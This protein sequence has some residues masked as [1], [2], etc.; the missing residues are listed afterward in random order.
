[1]K[2]SNTPS[3][4]LIDVQ[5]CQNRPHLEP[6]HRQ[7]NQNHH[8]T[9]LGLESAHFKLGL[10]DV[11]CQQPPYSEK[12]QRRAAEAQG[13]LVMMSGGPNKLCAGISQLSCPAIA[14]G[15]C[16]AGVLRGAGLFLPCSTGKPSPLQ[17]VRCSHVSATLGSPQLVRC[18]LRLLL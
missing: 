11:K 4:P 18:K 14:S 8:F 7:L 15:E 17:T 6:A 9:P 13:M 10:A 5:H 2:P 1:M 3:F 12:I 16:R